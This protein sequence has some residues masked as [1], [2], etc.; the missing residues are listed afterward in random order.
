MVLYY[1]SNTSIINVYNSA[2]NHHSILFLKFVYK[3]FHLS[4]QH[5]NHKPFGD[6]VIKCT[7]SKLLL[8]LFYNSC[9]RQNEKCIHFCAT[10]SFWY[11]ASFRTNTG[12]FMSWKINITGNE[13]KT[14]QLLLFWN[15]L[16]NLTIFWFLFLY[17]RTIKIF[18]KHVHINVKRNMSTDI[19]CYKETDIKKFHSYTTNFLL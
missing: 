9:T 6:Q 13:L 7:Y 15:V 11:W 5:L 2:I 4:T 8:I 3:I 1:V 14:H 17:N 12:S 19:P 10:M 18:T 16:N